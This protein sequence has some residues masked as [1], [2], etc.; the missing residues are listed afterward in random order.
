MLCCAVSW[1]GLVFAGGESRRMGRDKALLEIGGATLLQRAVTLVRRAGGTP[2]VVGRRRPPDQVS[3]AQQIDEVS[4]AG[5]PA[6][7][8]L[9]ALRWGLAD[10]G[11]ERVLALACD[12]PFVTV[13]LIHHLIA[14]SGGVDMVVPR[15]GGVMH[16]LAAVYTCDCLPAIDR[17]L[18]T[19]QRAVHGLIDDLRVRIVDEDELARFGGAR[20]LDN[21]NTPEDLARAKAVL[22]MEEG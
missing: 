10:G 3:G 6:S 22:D 5:R 14:Q 21:I 12:L 9:M 8:P 17:R 15:C 18:A 20:L 2:F 16:V 19:G 7:G 11:A 13:D 4:R 1:S